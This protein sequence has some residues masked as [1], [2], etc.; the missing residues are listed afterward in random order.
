MK[1]HLWVDTHIGKFLARSGAEES[2][3]N[4]FICTILLPK[5]ASDDILGSP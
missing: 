4:G 2:Y 3:E 5:K 1:S